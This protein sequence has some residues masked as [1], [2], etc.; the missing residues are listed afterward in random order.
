VKAVDVVLVTVV[1]GVGALTFIKRDVLF[2]YLNKQSA[3]NSSPSDSNDS[4]PAPTTPQGAGSDGVGWIYP[5]KPNG[6]LW[7]MS[8]SKPLEGDSGTLAIGRAITWSAINKSSDGKMWKTNAKPGATVKFNLNLGKQAQGDAIGGC[9]M[10]YGQSLSR[11]Y[12]YKT[13]VDV[14]NIE[15]T[16]FF[17][18]NNACSS[19]GVFL[20]GPC[21][22]HPGSPCCQEYD[23]DV[24]I[25]PGPGG[26][27]VF[28]KDHPDAANNFK[29]PGGKKSVN[30]PLNQVFGVKYI[31]MVK[32]RD[33]KNPRVRLECW[34]NLNG[35]KKTWSLVHSV[36]DYNGYN[37]GNPKASCGGTPYQVGAWRSPRMVVKWYGCSVDFNWWSMRE[38]APSG[39]VTF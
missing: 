18:A 34:L 36:E 30:I 28:T 16:A 26:Y 23:Y 19:D 39:A 12:T 5:S 27:V 25:K 32:S 8:Q 13:N 33:P 7:Y 6:Y 9:K 38:I 4:T 37:W 21:N 1:L 10:D 35:D 2:K 15:F 17:R 11:G 22:H 14:G 24:R 20:R 29:D 3:S 31:H